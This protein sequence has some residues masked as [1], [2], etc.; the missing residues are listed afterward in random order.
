MGGHPAY[1]L[2][3]PIP[4][5]KWRAMIRIASTVISCRESTIGGACMVL[6]NDPLVEKIHLMGRQAETGGFGLEL[7]SMRLV[8]MRG[9][10]HE[11]TF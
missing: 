6:L 3:A 11:H 10:T 2:S 8:S 5:S 4:K 1:P 7:G 9:L